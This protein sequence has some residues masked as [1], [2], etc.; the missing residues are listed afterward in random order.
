MFKRL[1][2]NSMPWNTGIPT[3]VYHF[4]PLQVHRKKRVHQPGK[5][6]IYSSRFV[7]SC[8]SCHF[9]VAQNRNTK[10]HALLLQHELKTRDIQQYHW[11]TELVIHVRNTWIQ[12]ENIGFPHIMS[13]RHFCESC[14]D[15]NCWFY[16]RTCCIATILDCSTDPTRTNLQNFPL[17]LL[18][19][20]VSRNHQDFWRMSVVGTIQSGLAQ[21]LGN[22]WFMCESVPRFERITFFGIIGSYHS[23]W[24]PAS[25]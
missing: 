2:Q 22:H 21:S 7:C 20:S 24:N 15:V 3:L 13:A 18:R 12:A 9:L 25:F 10:H 19:C 11:I 4:T 17:F 8:Y 16:W 14:S 6:I 23:D 1:Q 5:A